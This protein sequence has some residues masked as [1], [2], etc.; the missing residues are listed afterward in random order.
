MARSALRGFAAALLLA[1]LWSAA[2]SAQAQ[3]SPPGNPPDN[4]PSN[5]L[6]P[7]PG[8][9]GYSVPLTFQ[10]LQRRY[11]VIQPDYLQPGVP[12]VILLHPL[13][14]TPEIMAN[15]TRAGRLAAYFGVLVL[16]PEALNAHQWH[17]NPAPT[18]PEVN[19]PDD[20]GFVSA[21]IDLAVED[22]GVD[23]RRVYAAGYSN[24]G[25]M[26][27]RLA[28]ELAGRIAAVGV[29]AATLR[30]PLAQS[31]APSRTVP[32]A[33]M[34]GTADPIVPYAGQS[35]SQSTQQS[36]SAAQATQFWLGT[37]NCVPY[38][39]QHP[40][41]TQ[42]SDPTSVT[43]SIYSP[44]GNGTEVRVYTVGD[45]GHTWPGASYQGMNDPWFQLLGNTTTLMDAT[46]ELWMM[47]SR[48][49]QWRSPGPPWH[50][51]PWDGQAGG[52]QNAH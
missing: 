19:E 23:P 46:L 26:T 6:I 16:L 13:G 52:L 15:V 9:I 28:C 49:S 38:A 4:P 51:P 25:F 11:V 45:G 29:V 18:G 8:T 32:M 47:F 33:L 35:N 40:F 41:P 31:C 10:Q 39:V 44:C 42:E 14:T 1:V 12:L 30:A 27:E 48:R 17:D 34:L 24:G 5:P 43:L 36:L 2:S 22:Y 3:N 50:F 20:V 37:N 21:L 7:T